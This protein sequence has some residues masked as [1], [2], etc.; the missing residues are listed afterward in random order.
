M[1]RIRDLPHKSVLG[2]AWPMILSNISVPLLGIVDTAILG[3]LPSPMYLS[4]VALGASLLSMLFWSFGFL[5][6]GTTSLTAQAHGS[7][8]SDRT[9][10]VLM[11]SLA[12]AGLVGGLLLLLR[13]PI[14]N[15][16]ITLM[17]PSADTAH[18]AG[19]Y[20]RIRLL[21][22][23]LVLCNV[24][25][26]GWFIG[27]QNTRVPL[28]LLVTTNLINLLLDMVFIWG[29]EL[30]SR[31]AA[32][33]TVCADCCAFV[34]GMLCIARS[35]PR[36][37]QQLLAHLPLRWRQIKPLLIINQHLFIRTL[38]LLLGLSFFNAQGAQMGDTILAAN[39]IIFQLLMLCS[40][41]LDGIAHASEAL[42]GHSTGAKQYQRTRD[43]LVTT[44]IWSLTIAAIMSLFFALAQPVLITFFTDIASVQQALQQVF[45]WII[46]L[47]LIS[48]WGYWLDGVFI[49]LG[50]SK[51]MLNTMLL[52]VF[53]VFF[54][55]WFITQPWGNHGL[56]LAFSLL[57]LARGIGLAWSLAMRT[58]N[59]SNGVSI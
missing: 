52:A 51:A 46:A 15:S 5:R 8:D 36:W 23:P 42:I 22:A 49:G 41:G 2:L 12:L 6:M 27:R 14:I 30:N 56:W 11:H 38:C 58:K 31:G 44:G 26:L 13:A 59:P 20:G 37:Y 57:N 34:I 21:S 35:H 47:P 3:H 54:P 19:E 40:Y 28:M 53:V 18:L 33:A 10:E 45:P 48:V 32:L 50:D 55:V 9:Y 39:A 24:V 7:K 25:I 1:T 17:D 16:A 43:T 29:F 4:A